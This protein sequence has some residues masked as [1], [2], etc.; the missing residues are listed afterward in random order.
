MLESHLM[1]YFLSRSIAYQ[2]NAA[3]DFVPKR[4]DPAAAPPLLPYLNSPWF[5]GRLHPQ[6][7]ST[8]TTS[9]RPVPTRGSA[10]VWDPLRLRAHLCLVT[11]HLSTKNDNICT[12]FCGMSDSLWISHF[13]CYPK[14][15]APRMD[16]INGKIWTRFSVLKLIQ[17][18][19]IYTIFVKKMQKRLSVLQLIQLTPIYMVFV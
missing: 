8:E 5:T 11:R 2:A 14:H 10:R 1:F 15:F 4:R 17:L 7:D 13:H 19:P 18:T 16:I 12:F 3:H 9:T 6:E